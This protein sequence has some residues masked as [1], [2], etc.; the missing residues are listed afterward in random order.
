MGGEPPNRRLDCRVSKIAHVHLA[1]SAAAMSALTGEQSSFFIPEVRTVLRGMGA[2]FKSTHVLH[3]HVTTW[4]TC[5][6]EFG[7]SP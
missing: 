5:V 3:P 2:R 4:L 1:A 7:R 6:V